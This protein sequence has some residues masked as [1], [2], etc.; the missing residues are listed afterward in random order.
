[1]SHC[2]LVQFPC[3]PGKGEEL[4]AMLS[5]VLVDTRAFDG[6][7]SV[8]T[9]TD[10]DDPDLVMLWERW[11]T[12]EQ[13]ETYLTWRMDNGLLDALAPVMD[14]AKMRISHLDTHAA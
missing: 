12:R 13:Y 10:H 4:V 9:F 6:C 7:E 1:M 5:S 11:A 3:N 2:A 14:T 8:E